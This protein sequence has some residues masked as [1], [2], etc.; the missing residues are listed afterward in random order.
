MRGE[1]TDSTMVDDRRM[2]LQACAS[3]DVGLRRRVNEDRYALAPDLGLYV[4]A[5]GMG[6]HR[7]GQVASQL[8]AET[9]VR[10]TQAMHGAEA[11]PSEKLRQVLRY[12]NHQIFATAQ[13]QPEL[14]GMG[15]TL[16]A[17]L[18]VQGRIGLVHC[19]DSR[20]YLIRGGQIRCLTSDHSLVGELLRRQEIS[21]AAA[22][23]HPHRHVL[24]RALGVRP[25][26]EGDYVEMTPQDGDVFAL[27]S[28]GLT[29]LVKDEEIA[30]AIVRNRNLQDACDAL[31]AWANERGGDDNIT[32]VLV[33]CEKAGAPLAPI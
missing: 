1:H 19:G 21:E 7:A 30:S 26:V 5:D 20:A 14:S 17:L 11:S 8:A 9:A 24:T 25:Q 15:T 31:V 27:C 32:V 4:V 2:I 6:G 13:A 22:R 33:R 10:T 29:N 28:D 23:E 16:V 18:A 3:S 12:A